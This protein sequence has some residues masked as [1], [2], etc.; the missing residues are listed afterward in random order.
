MGCPRKLLCWQSK[1]FYPDRAPRHR[2]GGWGNPGELLCQVARSLGFYGDG[3]VSG[4]SLANHSDS[5]SFLAPWSAKTN[6][7]E[8]D[9]GRRSDTGVSFWLFLDSFGWWWL[10]SSLFFTKTSCHETIHANSYCGAWP[11]WAVSVSVLPLTIEYKCKSK[12]NS[13]NTGSDLLFPITIINNLNVSEFLEGE[14][15]LWEKANINS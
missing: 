5:G 4:L 7:S 9:S 1:R 12:R 2:A 14:T 13:S 8:K 6:A 3:I 10:I 15:L 11:G